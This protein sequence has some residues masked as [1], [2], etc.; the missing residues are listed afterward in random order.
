MR[1]FFAITCLSLVSGF[2][3]FGSDAKACDGYVVTR[4]VPT[5]QVI[6]RTTPVTHYAPVVY[7]ARKPVVAVEQAVVTVTQAAV[8]RVA[9][10]AVEPRVRV[11]AGSTLNAKSSFLGRETGVVFLK[12]GSITHRCQVHSWGDE[13]TTFT[14][15]ALNVSSEIDASIEVVR[16]N[17]D[18]VKRIAVRLASPV[19]LVQVASPRVAPHEVESFNTAPAVP[20]SVSVSRAEV[21]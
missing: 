11:E 15:P 5:T 19:S 16:S 7:E 13:A 14:L 1:R 20:A 10:V 18:V 12:H 3:S 4:P 17:G 6:Y 21:N 9:V 8:E 2:S